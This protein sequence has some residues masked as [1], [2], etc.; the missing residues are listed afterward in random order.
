MK[1]TYKKMWK[2]LIDRDMKQ[3]D[4]SELTGISSFTITKMRNDDIVNVDT[5]VRICE[6]LDCRIEDIVEL[7]QTN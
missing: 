7:V 5:L 3:K 2:L 1:A 6:A 4:L